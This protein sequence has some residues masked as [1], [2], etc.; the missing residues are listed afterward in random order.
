MEENKK[1]LNARQLNTPEI[2]VAEIEAGNDALKER[3]KL[4]K[5]MEDARYGEMKLEERL[6]FLREKRI[7][8]AKKLFETNDEAEWYKMQQE[9]FGLRTKIQEIK[10]EM[11]NS[12]MDFLKGME[13][14]DLD[15]NLTVKHEFYKPQ[16]ADAVEKGTVEA[17]R[18][19]LAGKNPTLDYARATSE[20]TAK[21]I[22]EQKI[23]NQALKP[24]AA[25][26]VA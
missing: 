20:N 7:D 18:A 9:D 24:I 21:M 11:E 3:L 10:K 15:T 19:E 17:Y 6:Q 13:S 8:L 16:F 5:M 4:E 26:G 12:V 22:A 25:L 23:L 2:S 1:T 14:I